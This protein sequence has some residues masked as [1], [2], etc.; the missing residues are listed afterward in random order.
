M[1]TGSVV[2]T[3]VR[4]VVRG[5]LSVAVSGQ[6]LVRSVEEQNP[7]EFVHGVARG[8]TSLLRHTVGGV[9]N[10]ASCITDNLSKQMSNL[11]FDRVSEQA[12][13]AGG[14][15]HLSHRCLEDARPQV[16]QT[17]CYLYA[18][19]YKMQREKREARKDKPA[20][21]LEGLGSGGKR[22]AKGLVDG[23]T[24]VRRPASCWW[25]H[26]RAGSS[27]AGLDVLWPVGWLLACRC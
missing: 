10:S 21:V 20:D 25:R 27:K 16:H 4:D 3:L 11:A 22:F 13:E 12:G 9:A 14:K 8:G 1:L 18:Q 5:S 2:P 17:V 26:G 7:E 6:G 23:V 24:G 15:G 19:E